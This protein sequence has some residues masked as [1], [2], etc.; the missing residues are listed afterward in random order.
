MI[1]KGEVSSRLALSGQ[2]RALLRSLAQKSN[3]LSKIYL[4]GIQVLHDRT[5]P[6][7]FSLAAHAIRE[8]IEKIPEHLDVPVKAQKETAKG[9]IR[10]IEEFWQRATA[11]S[12]CHNDGLWNGKIDGPL[13]KLL[14]K[15]DSFFD[16]FRNHYPRRCARLGSN[17]S[18]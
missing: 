8:L 13:R 7:A 14:T 12:R 11:N 2:Q 5:N 6:D 17:L 3:E 9:K 16:W 10:E 4:G 15:V 1:P 18:S